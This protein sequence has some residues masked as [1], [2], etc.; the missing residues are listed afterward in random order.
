M[1]F[2]FLRLFPPQVDD[3][4]NHEEVENFY[5][6]QKWHTE[7]QTEHPADMR[8]QSDKAK[9][10]GSPE[11]KEFVPCKVDWHRGLG[12]LLA[13]VEAFDFFRVYVCKVL[14]GV[15]SRQTAT[16]FEGWAF[17]VEKGERDLIKTLIVGV[18][19]ANASSI[20]T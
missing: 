14:N 13:T 8:Q 18:L 15:A 10:R 16:S 19:V 12:I 7:K 11:D 20:I 2:K 17:L 6:R 1:Y 4:T 5:N 3:E 9:A